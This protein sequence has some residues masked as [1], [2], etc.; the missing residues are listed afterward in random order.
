MGLLMLI[1]SLRSCFAPLLLLNELCLLLIPL[2]W[3]HFVS[4]LT[5]PPQRLIILPKRIFLSLLRGAEAFDLRLL[6]SIFR[7]RPCVA[8]CVVLCAVSA[9]LAIFLGFCLVLSVPVAALARLYAKIVS[10]RT[11]SRALNAI[12][13]NFE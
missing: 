3:L 7:K 4:I 13:A 11:Q 9:I 1:T 12:C 2:L 6:Q 8:E 5:L 10:L